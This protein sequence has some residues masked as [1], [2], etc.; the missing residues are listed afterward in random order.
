MG[1]AKDAGIFDYGLHNL[2]DWSED[3]WKRIDDTP[4]GG[5][6]GMVMKCEP[7]FSCHD[8]LSKERDYDEV[9]YMAA[10]GELL[11]Q[12]IA[13]E[14]SMKSN[15]M[16]ICGHY[17]GID[18]RIRQTIVTREI[19]IGEYVLTGGELPAMVLMDAVVRLIPGAIGDSESALSD[20]FMD[21]LLEAPIYTKPRE[22]RGLEVP[23]ILL[24]GNHAAIEKWRQEEALLKTKQRRPDLLDPNNS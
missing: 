5:G 1:R 2:H 17:K 23:E 11:T 6:A 16:I 14:L 10:D 20:S 7:V 18:E 15:L 9:I 3:K 19:S 24:S 8:S 4:Y 21:G 12:E 22:F 13:N